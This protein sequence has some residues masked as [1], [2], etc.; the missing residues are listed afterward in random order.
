MSFRSSSSKSSFKNTWEIFLYDYLF[1]HFFFWFPRQLCLEKKLFVIFLA[2]F[3]K[4]LLKSLE[5]LNFLHRFYGN[6]SRHFWDS[7]FKK[8]YDNFVSQ[9]V[10]FS[11]RIPSGIVL[12]NSLC[13]LP[14][15]HF[16]FPQKSLKKCLKIFI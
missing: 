5:F 6:W 14:A 8:S 13:I 15:I 10:G 12:E 3:R 1:W 7:W 11:Q 16:G 9:F 2:F 4:S